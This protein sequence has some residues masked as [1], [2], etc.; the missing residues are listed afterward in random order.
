VSLRAKRSNLGATVPTL[1]EIASSPAAPRNDTFWL[2]S[3]EEPEATVH[4][5]RSSDGATPIGSSVG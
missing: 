1:V 2:F 4:A 5:P 3:C